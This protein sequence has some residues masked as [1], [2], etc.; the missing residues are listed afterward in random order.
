MK[1]RK[2]LIL[3]FIANI[4]SGAGQGI[5]MIAV[6]WYFAKIESM[7][8]FGYAYIAVNLISLFWVPYAG[9]LVDRFN[10][11][12]VFLVLNFVTGSLLASI[13]LFGYLTGSLPWFFIAGAFCLTFLNYNIHYTALYALVQEISEKKFYSKISQCISFLRK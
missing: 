7:Q 5:S 6:P 4:I 3:L 11:K 10:R 2:A 12:K 13:S 9:S 8:I 1:N